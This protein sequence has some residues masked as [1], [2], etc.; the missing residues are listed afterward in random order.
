MVLGF[1][2]HYSPLMQRIK[3]LLSFAHMVITLKLS[4]VTLCSQSGAYAS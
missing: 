2:V 1:R 3:G 4:V